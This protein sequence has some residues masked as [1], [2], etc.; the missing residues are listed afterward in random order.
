M[1]TASTPA[2]AVSLVAVLCSLGLGGAL[3]VTLAV[4]R[5]HPGLLSPD[6]GPF[7]P[8]PIPKLDVN[9]RLGPRSLE[10]ALSVADRSWIGTLVDL[11]GG[12]PGTGLKAQIEAARP[13]EDRVAVFMNLDGTG[14]CGARWAEREAIALRQGKALGARGLAVVGLPAE[15][16]VSTESAPLWTTCASLSLPVSTAGTPIS[17]VAVAASRHPDTIFIAAPS[18]AAPADLTALLND[19]PN[20]HVDLAGW[21]K[22]LAM[23]PEPSRRAILDHPDRFLYGSGVRYVEEGER[24][25]IVLGAGR[26]ILLDREL[27]GGLER[28]TF[29]FEPYRILETRDCWVP[30]PSRPEL[31]P[32]GEDRDR[33]LCGL[34]LPGDV[35]ARIYH[36]NAERILGIRLGGRR[37]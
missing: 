8:L 13:H 26:P 19:R 30:E 37:E 17:A 24:R 25:G 7:P 27:L 20:L 4:E 11:A 6:P 12:T 9:Q 5:A 21:T 29:F 32:I 34:G 14:C 10:L 36:R 22:T 1:N 35:L 31:Q 33:Q 16:F 28:R 2:R 3:A 23:D 15:A 18:G